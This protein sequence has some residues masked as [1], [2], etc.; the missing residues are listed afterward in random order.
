MNPCTLGWYLPILVNDANGAPKSSDVM[1]ASNSPPSSIS[2]TESDLGESSALQIYHSEIQPRPPAPPRPQ[3]QETTWQDLDAKFRRDLPDELYMD[4][5]AYRGLV[6]RACPRI[7]TLDG[8]TIG[9]P[10]RV[11]AEKLL[12]KML[13]SREAGKGQEVAMM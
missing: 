6:M 8:V 13:K 3:R 9:E 12:I 2:R 1:P 4:R 10:E 7:R 5:L 11:K